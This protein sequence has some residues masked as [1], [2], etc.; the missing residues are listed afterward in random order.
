MALR[1]AP[2][3]ARAA[4]TLAAAAAAFSSPSTT[5]RR[6]LTTSP[7]LRKAP[8]TRQQQPP[9]PSTLSATPPTDFA[10]LN[11]LGDT[12]APA[13][14]IES[15]TRA[16]G[17]YM[18]NGTRVGAGDG[19]LLIAGEVFRWRPWEGQGGG[20]GAQ[21]CVNELGQFEVPKEAF[22]VLDLLWPKPDLIVL[23]VGPTMRPLAPATRDH[24]ASLGLRVEVLDDRNARAQ[25][26]L[27]ATERG[28][29]VIAAALMPPR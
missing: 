8:T 9:P 20:G 29:D 3:A 27:L 7:L 18:N 12:Q 22:G 14:S 25:Y 23:G 19:V 17:F 4:P 6:H 2:R 13:T 1:I 24:L 16:G 15:A 21:D 10:S 11:V 5:T 26:N 28:Q